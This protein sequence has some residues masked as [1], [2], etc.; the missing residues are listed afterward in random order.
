MFSGIGGLELGLERT[1]HFQT[2]WNS[3]IEPYACAVLRKH[4]PS[5]PN[6][7]DITK[8]DWAGGGVEKPDLICGGFPCQDIS[9]AGK[10]AGIKEGTRSGLWFEFH[11]AIRSLRPQY[12]LVEN[13]S[14]LSFRGLCTV[15]GDLAQIGYDAEWFTLRAS[16]VGAPHRRERLFI[17]AYPSRERCVDSEP[18]EFAN[19][20]GK[21]SLDDASKSV[22]APDSSRGGRDDWENHREND[23]VRQIEGRELSEIQPNGDGREHRP[24]ADAYANPADSWSDGIQ[25]FTEEQIRRF[26]EFKAFENLRSVADLAGRPDIPQ[27]LIR[28]GDNGVPCWVDRIKCLGNAVVP[29]VAQV[30][31][32]AIIESENKM[33]FCASCSRG[34]RPNRDC[35]KH[36]RTG[37]D[38]GR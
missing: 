22:N 16:D 30:I 27:P 12:A 29:Q 17:V 25:R 31:G 4:W 6:L 36:G 23:G 7:G 15:L 21:P 14:A 26:P 19:Q 33:K 38:E 34:G 37:M 24:I 5:V 9:T 2:I 10:G 1:G 18:K 8:I 32:E 20:R 13:V 28:G 11:K 3:E 35:P